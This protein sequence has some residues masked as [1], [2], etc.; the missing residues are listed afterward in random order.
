MRAPTKATSV[1]NAFLEIQEK[2]NS[3]FPRIDQMKLDK[4][5]YYAHA[6]W[7]A[8]TSEALFSED[9]QAGQ[10]GP[11]IR[12]VHNEFKDYGQFPIEKGR[13]AMELVRVGESPINFELKQS[14]SVPKNVFLFLNN[15]WETHKRFTGIQLSNATHVLGEPWTIVKN[16][17]GSLEN[18]PKIPNE[19]IRDVFRAKLSS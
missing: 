9:V 2:D 13:R 15:V 1:A 11:V 12:S 8:W 7:L 17:Y 4:L 6:W 19:L 10:W 3:V 14:P 5:V 18:T 16:Q